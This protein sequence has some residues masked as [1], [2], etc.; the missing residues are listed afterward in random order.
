MSLTVTLEV[1]VALAAM[2]AAQEPR[3]VTQLLITTPACVEVMER[4][5]PLFGSLGVCSAMA[6]SGAYMAAI[7][8]S[9]SERILLGVGYPELRPFTV[10]TAVARYEVSVPRLLARASITVWGGSA[11]TVRA[12]VSIPVAKWETL[13]D[14]GDGVGT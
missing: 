8:E 14:G 9:E 6:L 7:H 1:L 12:A 11:P 4:R 3:S 5:G 10:A 2:T 13:R